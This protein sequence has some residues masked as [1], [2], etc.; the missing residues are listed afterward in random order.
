MAF[1]TRDCVARHCPETV[2]DIQNDV[3]CA[4]AKLK[5]AG[6]PFVDSSSC[7]VG[8]SDCA[9]RQ[10]NARNSLHVGFLCDAN[11]ALDDGNTEMPHA[12]VRVTAALSRIR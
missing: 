3:R 2:S 9:L 12:K 4:I 1:L 10:P 5:A 11:L 7:R 8:G 6:V